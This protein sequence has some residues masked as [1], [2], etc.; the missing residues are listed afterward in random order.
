M[1]GTDDP[2]RPAA[3]D[4]DGTGTGTGQGTRNGPA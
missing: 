4:P 2:I 1:N 3:G